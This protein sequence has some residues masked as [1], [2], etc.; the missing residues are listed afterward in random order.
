MERL[1]VS[2]NND[3]GYPWQIYKVKKITEKFSKKY[4]GL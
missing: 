1:S 2:S 4:E 3:F